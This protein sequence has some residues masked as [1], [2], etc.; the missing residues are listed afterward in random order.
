[1]L[2]STIFYAAK[3]NPS[4]DK[5]IND[6]GIPVYSEAI[7]TNGSKDAGFRFATSQLPEEVQQVILVRVQIIY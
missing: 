6:T 4:D 7:F 3:L 1:M 2:S 5:L